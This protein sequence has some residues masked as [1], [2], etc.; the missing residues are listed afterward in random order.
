M[1][2]I[3]GAVLI[4]EYQTAGRGRHGRS[5][6]AP[7][8]SQITLSVGVSVVDVPSDAWGWLPLLTGVAVVDAVRRARRAWR[9][10]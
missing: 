10:A 4:A 6:S 5:W 9:R 1:S 3:D 8:R 2:D 7:P